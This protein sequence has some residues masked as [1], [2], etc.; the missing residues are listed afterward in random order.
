MAEPL[1][2][3]TKQRILASPASKALAFPGCRPV[4]IPCPRI[5]DHE[6]RFEYWDV[7]TE[8]AMVVRNLNRIFG[9][10]KQGAAA[11]WG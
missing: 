5:A 1:H 7:D 2:S 3:P 6:G 8:V 9:C 10:A 11:R 4:R